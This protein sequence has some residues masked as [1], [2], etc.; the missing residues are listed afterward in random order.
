[1][2]Q[3]KRLHDCGL[4]VVGFGVDGTKESWEKQNK[5]HN[6]ILEFQTAASAVEKAEIAVE[7]LMVMGFQSDTIMTLLRGLKFSLQEAWKGRIIRPYLAKSQTPAG[8]WQT[9]DPLVK[10][11]VQDPTL[12]S[13]L[14]YAMI[15]SVQTHPKLFHRMAANGAYLA[16]IGLLAPF[17]KCPTRP[18]VP[19]PKGF[20]RS[21][22]HLINRF[23]PFDK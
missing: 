21:I 12:L 11:M 7:V 15:G 2:P 19:V 17:G 23:M 13:R 10:A 9:N 20:G 4:E 22:A 16:L 1:M 6:S 5:T 14:D 3:T 18:L 8:R